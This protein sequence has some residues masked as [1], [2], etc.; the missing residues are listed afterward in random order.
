MCMIVFRKLV[1]EDV[2][3]EKDAVILSWLICQGDKEIMVENVMSGLEITE[4]RAVKFLKK[5]YNRGFLKMESA[6]DKTFFK[7]DLAFVR[8]IFERIG[9]KLTED[10]PEKIRKLISDLYINNNINNINKLNNNLNNKKENLIEENNNLNRSEIQKSEKTEKTEEN[11]AVVEVT[12][13]RRGRPKKALDPSAKRGTVANP[14]PNPVSADEVEET[15]HLWT[16]THPDWETRLDY[17]ATA[18]KFFNNYAAKG[19]M[20]GNSKICNWF[21]LLSNALS[22]CCVYKQ[23]DEE[24][25]HY[26]PSAGSPFSAEKQTIDIN[27]QVVD[28][29]PEQLPEFCTRFN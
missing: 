15:L 23:A 8:E 9:E 27:A 6:K 5:F 16:R 21:A 3:T 11:R 25:F 19:W 28:D 18:E 20:Q 4:G 29:E 2:C 22:W 26:I 7:V 12:P 24:E 14:I 1:T 17:K 10:L 13:K